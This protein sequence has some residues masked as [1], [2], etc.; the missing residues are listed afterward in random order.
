MPIPQLFVAVRVCV[1]FYSFNIERGHVTLGC[2]Y[3]YQKPGF[4][5]K[6]GLFK[7][8]RAFSKVRS[9]FKSPVF[10][11]KSGLLKKSTFYQKFRVF[12]ITTFS[13]LVIFTTLIFSV[14]LYH[15]MFKN[16]DQKTFCFKKARA[17]QKKRIN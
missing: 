7:K 14:N 15:T 6:P 9:F 11:Q 16:Q 1:N 4:F 13:K 2:V 5:Q 8:T 17:F 12:K 10:F 3:R